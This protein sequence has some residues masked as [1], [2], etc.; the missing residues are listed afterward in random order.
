MNVSIIAY[1]EAGH[2]VAARWLGI[3]VR[4]VSIVGEAGSKGRVH[5]APTI[6][7][8]VA[9]AYEFRT[10]LTSFEG[11]AAA[12]RTAV[13]ALAGPVAQR[14]HSPRSVRRW[15]VHAD[16]KAVSLVAE[17]IGCDDEQEMK[18]WY[19]RALRRTE[20]LLDDKW[21]AVESLAKELTKKRKLSRDEAELAMCR[22]YQM[23]AAE[24]RRPTRSLKHKRV[25][26]TKAT[27][28]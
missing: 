19:Q 21:L 3:K 12:L 23:P 9:R 4:R 24:K 25:R 2:A 17:R 11:E 7:S 8:K 10:S 16:Y 27:G 6:S 13:I 14:K 22:P 18:H 15:H 26:T 1:H 20:R 28:A 5:H